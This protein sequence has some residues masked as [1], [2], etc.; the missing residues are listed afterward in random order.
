MI[1]HTSFILPDSWYLRPEQCRSRV[2]TRQWQE[3]LL[4]ERDT[5]IALG[6]IW[7]LLSYKVGPGVYELRAEKKNIDK[8]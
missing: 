3:M 6:Q 2:T 7:Q 5:F 1:K 4:E 8:T